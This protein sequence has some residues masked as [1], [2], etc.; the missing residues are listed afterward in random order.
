MMPVEL[1][2][3][4]RTDHVV[5]GRRQAVPPVG[6]LLVA[7]AGIAI[8]VGDGAGTAAGGAPLAYDLAFTV[9]TFGLVRW[10][11]AAAVAP[12][13]VAQGE[14]RSRLPLILAVLGVVAIVWPWLDMWITHARLLGDGLSSV[15]QVANWR[16]AL[17]DPLGLAESPFRPLWATSVGI[18]LAGLVVIGLVVAGRRRLRRRT[19]LWSCLAG[20][21]L[22]A[23]WCALLAHLHAMSVADTWVLGI[24]PASLPPWLRRF[25][26]L[27]VD[28]EQL[29]ILFGTDTRASAMFVGT[30]AALLVDGGLA[31]RFGESLRRW[32]GLAAAALA[33]GLTAATSAQSPWLP[34]GAVLVT[35]VLVAPVTC[36]SS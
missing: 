26:D 27:G 16:Y 8:L 14:V 30:A 12:S 32:V 10:A 9:G 22:S 21:L 28:P 35:D 1:P 19:V 15:L 33:V 34:Y 20:A 5:P 6:W 4:L 24:D 29:R 2:R 11:R 7:I 36:R 18:Q 31:P 25:F 23:A 3:S 13:R 17:G